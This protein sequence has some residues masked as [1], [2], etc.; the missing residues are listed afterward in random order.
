M[1]F[2]FL[3]EYHGC[4]YDWSRTLCA[5]TRV[6]IIAT[7]SN[8]LNATMGKAYGTAMDACRTMYCNT[9]NLVSSE[10]AWTIRDLSG[11]LSGL[12]RNSAGTAVDDPYYN[13]PAKFRRAYS[14]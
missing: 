5:Q 8:V 7:L 3:S 12:K 2:V 6:T 11:I 10:T 4:D 14:S 13:F 9:L 1:V